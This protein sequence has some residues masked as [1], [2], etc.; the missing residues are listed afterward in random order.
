MIINRRLHDISWKTKIVS[1]STPTTLCV[2]SSKYLSL[3]VME[4]LFIRSLSPNLCVQKSS[5]TSLQL[6]R[7]F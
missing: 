5:V 6:F 4:A 3:D 1:G 7:S 2:C